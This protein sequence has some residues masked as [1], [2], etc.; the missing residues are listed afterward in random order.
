MSA[1]E[2][3]VLRYWQC[4]GNGTFKCVLSRLESTE[5]MVGSPSTEHG[6]KGKCPA[7]SSAGELQMPEPN[8]IYVFELC[9]NI[10]TTLWQV[11]V[12]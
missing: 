7:P 12:K 6:L 1:T 11:L 3:A 9:F 8:F 5:S 4:R 10:L 2:T